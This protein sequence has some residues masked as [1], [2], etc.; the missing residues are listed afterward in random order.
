MLV[1]QQMMSCWNKQAV[2]HFLFEFPVIVLWTTHA[3]M[4]VVAL[5]TFN[6]C[7]TYILDLGWRFYSH[8]CPPVNK[9]CICRALWLQMFAPFS[10]YRLEAT[11]KTKESAFCFKFSWFDVCLR[12]QILCVIYLIQFVT[13]TL[14]I[15]HK[16]SANIIQNVKLS[17]KPNCRSMH[18]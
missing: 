6:V 9:Y 2:Q 3:S 14:E 8:C 13:C 7:K 5:H 10:F 4:H 12:N 1:F 17:H 18:V 15:G 16:M 11:F